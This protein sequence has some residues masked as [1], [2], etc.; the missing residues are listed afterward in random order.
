MTDER[1]D[2]A[3]LYNNYGFEYRQDFAEPGLMVFYYNSGCF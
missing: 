1:N 2:I 3:E